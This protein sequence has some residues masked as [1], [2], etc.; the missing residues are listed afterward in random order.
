MA[1]TD[2]KGTTWYVPAGWT[3]TAGYGS[4]SIHGKIDDYYTANPLYIGYAFDEENMGFVPKANSIVDHGFFSWTSADSFTLS[5]TGGA[6]ATAPDLIACLEANGTQLKVTDLT[7][8][9]WTVASG[10]QAEADYGKFVINGTFAS[11]SYSSPTEFIE[12]WVGSLKNGSASSDYVTFV[13]PLYDVLGSPVN[14]AI[15]NTNLLTISIAGGTDVTNSKLI[16]WL[17]KYGEL[18]ENI[19]DLTGYTWVGGSTWKTNATAGFGKFQVAGWVSHDLEY[20]YTFNIGYSMVFVPDVLDFAEDGSILLSTRPLFY[21]DGMIITFEDGADVTNPKLISWLLENGTLTKEETPTETIS[22]TYGG[23]TIATL[24]EGQ[25]AT[26][27]CGG[28]KM[29]TDI[30]IKFGTIGA[31]IYNNKTTEVQADQLATLECG[32]KRA[33]TSIVVKAFK[34]KDVIASSKE[35]F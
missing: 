4:F 2:L 7:N 24:E 33:I 30:V 27:N 29:L 3:A 12:L 14:Y 26:L 31:I 15:N 11:D 8:T 16:A 13:D 5:I 1:I 18:K 25:T 17:S 22:I 23:E 6:D 21:E 34:D 10:W 35:D 28:K 19:T 32:G 9:T 20:F